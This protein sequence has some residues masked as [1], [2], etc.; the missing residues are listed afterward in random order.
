[1]STLMDGTLRKIIGKNNPDSSSDKLTINSDLISL[2]SF[3]N[4]TN[5][6]RI[7]LKSFFGF[8]IIGLILQLL[9]PSYYF[10]YFYI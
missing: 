1:M 5:T 10:R 8:G 9:L 6:S 7:F 4:S 2:T 3:D